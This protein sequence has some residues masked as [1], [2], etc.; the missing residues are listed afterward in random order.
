MPDA[1]SPDSISA[2]VPSSTAFATSDA[3]ARLGRGCTIIDSSIWV[4]VMTI[5][6]CALVRLISRFCTSGTFSGPSSTPRSPRAT[7]VPSDAAMISS[8]RSSACGFSI[9]AIT[10]MCWPSAVSRRLAS[11]TSSG[12]RT[13]DSAT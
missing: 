7:I 10:G 8:R 3:S 6:P 12:R 11:I 1:V 13:N 4:A 5:L 9:L 2:S